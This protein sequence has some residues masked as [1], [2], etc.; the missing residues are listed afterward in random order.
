MLSYGS[1]RPCECT[2]CLCFAEYYIE[3]FTFSNTTLANFSVK[4]SFA[5][6]IILVLEISNL[7]SSGINLRNIKL[8][9]PPKTAKRESYIYIDNR[10]VYVLRLRY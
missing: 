5:M 6:H 10:M 8:V 3:R 2:V 9:R 1:Q 7:H 4:L